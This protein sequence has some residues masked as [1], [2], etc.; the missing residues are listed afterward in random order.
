MR[1]AM[2]SLSQKLCRIHFRVCW[3]HSDILTFMYIRGFGLDERY[4]RAL[5]IIIILFSSFLGSLKSRGPRQLPCSYHCIHKHQENMASEMLSNFFRSRYHDTLLNCYY[6][7]CF[8]RRPWCWHKS[9]R[10]L[11]QL[12]LPPSFLL[13]LSAT[14]LDSIYFAFINLVS[15][16]TTAAQFSSS[17]LF[18]LM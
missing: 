10:P 15:S 18:H 14:T 17:P 4:R 2:V 8:W 13:S 9:Y 6:S 3:S 12:Q 5:K 16:V 1:I 7:S 11:R